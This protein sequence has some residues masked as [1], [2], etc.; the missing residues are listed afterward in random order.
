MMIAKWFCLYFLTISFFTLCLGQET[1]KDINKDLVVYVL[2][3]VNAEGN[4]ITGLRLIVEN[5]SDK[6]YWIRE[7]DFKPERIDIDTKMEDGSSTSSRGPGI[8]VLTGKGASDLENVF[9]KVLPKSMIGVTLEL[10][11]ERYI[12]WAKYIDNKI[13][14]F[15][16]TEIKT[17]E[18]E[19]RP[20]SRTSLETKLIKTPFSLEP[21]KSK[22]EVETKK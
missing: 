15:I 20:K 3:E 8:K 4:T 9:I 19:E 21:T 10:T 6:P 2:P 16:S 5:T 7:K 1:Q 11:A 13:S 18:N 14:I 12:K 22:E 17:N